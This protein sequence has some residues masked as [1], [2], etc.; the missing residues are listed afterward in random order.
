MSNSY[1]LDTNAAIA[2]LNGKP[3]IEP[4]IEVADEIF[5]PIIVVGELYYGAEKSGRVE[6]N[7]TKVDVFAAKYAILPC[8]VETCRHVGKIEHQIRS[9]GRPIPQNDIW[10]AAI[11]IQH[12]LTV[13]TR[14]KHFQAVDGLTVKGW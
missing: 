1:L 3:D 8:D 7:R 14:D 6:L 12:S 9:K 11:A 10:I 13:V 2:L 5:I 4:I